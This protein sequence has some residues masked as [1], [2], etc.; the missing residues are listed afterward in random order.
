MEKPLA[1]ILPILKQKTL[2][3]LKSKSELQFWQRRYYDF[4]VR[5]EEKT[6]EKLRYMHRNPVTRGLVSNPEDWPWPSYRHYQ[7]GQRGTIE[8]E[9]HW[10][11]FHREQ[12]SKEHS[13]IP[14][15]HPSPKLRGKDG[16][17]RE[18]W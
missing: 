11:A 16:A 14:E 2:R 13:A 8:I 15:S 7:T 1:I 5:T 3:R 17:P 6:A 18:L 9:S 10:T 12:I 4:N